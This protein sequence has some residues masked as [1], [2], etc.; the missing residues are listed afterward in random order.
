MLAFARQGSSAVDCLHVQR[1][2]DHPGSSALCGRME[3]KGLSSTATAVCIAS[4]GLLPIVAMG[5]SDGCVTVATASFLQDPSA[6]Q[7]GLGPQAVQAA[8]SKDPTGGVDIL[9]VATVDPCVTL[10]QSGAVTLDPEL[11]AHSVGG[12]AG[13]RGRAGTQP[14]SSSAL[15]GAAAGGFPCVPM[16]STW[17][18]SS[19][20]SL[21]FH[22]TLPL[23]A[24]ADLAGHVA[25][26]RIGVEDPSHALVAG[27]HL[28]T[29]LVPLGD[30][31]RS[32]GIRRML[33][34]R[35]WA[36]E[37]SLGTRAGAL[38]FAGDGPVLRAML[39]CPGQAV[40]SFWIDLF[41]G[42]SSA[43][44]IGPSLGGAE[45]QCVRAMG[46]DAAAALRAAGLTAK[47]A[48]GLAAL[49]V[50]P[51]PPPCMVGA[52]GRP[53]L[54]GSGEGA[55]AGCVAGGATVTLG[56]IN[57][58]GSSPVLAGALPLPASSYVIA[59]EGAL[60]FGWGA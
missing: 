4:H 53:W 48:S 22:P 30:S 10:D 12:A 54:L 19:V 2:L 3:I 41:T 38:S 27:T 20:C 32:Q 44:V 45:E 17:A 29:A 34:D 56:P 47:A 8:A 50:I 40:P 55:S 24:A 33:R 23:L 1:Q 15:S 42:H 6:L 11:A 9:M 13:H 28:P 7:L 35:H 18:A 58:A 16:P 49:A 51:T 46:L 21:A 37:A 14:S 59:G 26:W 52:G 36:A 25:V 39:Q 57:G 60:S 43:P 5:S 31:V